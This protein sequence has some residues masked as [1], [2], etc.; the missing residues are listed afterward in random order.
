MLSTMLRIIINNNIYITYIIASYCTSGP[1]H[2]PERQY[3]FHV[4]R[5]AVDML[6]AAC[7]MQEKIKIK[8]NTL[9]FK[10]PL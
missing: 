6:F 1:R 3:G 4:G 2:S 5:S 9:H 8:N 10:P 7:Q